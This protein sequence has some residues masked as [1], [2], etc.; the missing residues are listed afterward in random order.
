V[1]GCLD[2]RTDLDDLEKKQIIS[3]IIKIYKIS[4]GRTNVTLAY[5]VMIILHLSDFEYNTLG[6]LKPNIKHVRS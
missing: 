3:V 2:P 6:E 4:V 5:S 1:G